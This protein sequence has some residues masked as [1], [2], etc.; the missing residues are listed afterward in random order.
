MNG[1][2]SET[3]VRLNK[4][5]CQISKQREPTHLLLLSQR[6]RALLLSLAG[7]VLS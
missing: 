4:K 3:V 5:S 7:F 2:A 6:V 1:K